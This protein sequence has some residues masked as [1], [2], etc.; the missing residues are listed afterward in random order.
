MI[1]VKENED[2]TFT[3]S[4]DKDDPNEAVFNDYTAEDFINLIRDY[5]EK[6]LAESGELDDTFQQEFIQHEQ[7]IKESYEYF[8][9][10]TAEEVNEDINTAKEFIR[11]DEEDERLPRL[12]F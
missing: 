5:C 3:I 1:D 7:A 10:Q 4:W 11:K 9:D 2:G 6:I 8:I 12:F